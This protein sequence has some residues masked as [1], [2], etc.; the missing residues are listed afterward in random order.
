MADAG[1]IIAVTGVALVA[2]M[3]SLFLKES[4]LPVLAMLTAL[5]AGAIILIELLPSLQKLI[6]GFGSIS[7]ASGLNSYYLLLMLKIIGIAY[8]AE[9]GAQL[10]R[11]AGQGAIAIKIEFAAKIGIMMLSLPILSAVIQSVLA[12]FE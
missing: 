10:C 11:D 4:K 1:G 3:V 9:F 6:D 5:A 8:I 7:T 12:L 2:T